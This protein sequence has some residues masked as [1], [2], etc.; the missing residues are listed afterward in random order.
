MSF[1]M[2]LLTA[3][4]TAVAET[5]PI[6]I[7]KQCDHVA[8]YLDP[9][10]HVAVATWMIAAATTIAGGFGAVAAR[11]AAA[12]LRLEAEPAIVVSKEANKRIVPAAGYR[13]TGSNATGFQLDP[14]I[15]DTEQGFQRPNEPYLM[16]SFINTGRSPCVNLAT[17]VAVQALPHGSI[18]YVIAERTIRIRLINPNYNQAVIIVN[19]TDP[20]L[21]PMHVV[22][23]QD[24]TRTNARN[25][26][27]QAAIYASS[28]MYKMP[29]PTIE[30]PS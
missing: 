21:S 17:N 1:A 27:V 5:A 9:T 19:G 15:L 24:A 25:K 6:I 28:F 12:S 29:E 4:K 16:L 11:S 10:I 30:L 14:I 22:L 2:L 8:W 26:T 3:A 20:L 23:F 7:L 13:V 18:P